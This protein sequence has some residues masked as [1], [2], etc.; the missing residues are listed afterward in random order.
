MIVVQG[1]R[2]WAPKKVSLL[3]QE[4]SKI[5]LNFLKLEKFNSYIRLI[6]VTAL[7]LRFIDNFKKKRKKEDINT[8][9]FVMV[10]ER[11]KAENLWIR[12]IQMEIYK[13]NN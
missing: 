11:V 9:R 1:K 2:L 6:N 13:L 4:N 8:S 7:V 12:S 10:E 5:S 3:V